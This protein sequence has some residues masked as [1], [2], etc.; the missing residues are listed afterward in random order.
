MAIRATESLVAAIIEV[1]E[2]INLSPFIIA[3]NALVEEIAIDSGHDEA[4][5]TLI[6]TWLAAHFYAM[7]DPR[8]T[9]ERAGP[10]SASYQNKVDLFLSL[11]HYGQMAQTLD[12]S[13]LLMGL[14]GQKTRTASVQWAGKEVDRGLVADPTAVAEEEE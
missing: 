5:L 9:D 2:E 3:A 11:S 1:D 6:E 4:R 8:V 7:R 12:T 13:G 14:S 10:V